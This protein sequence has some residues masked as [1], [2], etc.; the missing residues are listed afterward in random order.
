ME[1]ILL[2]TII[3]LAVLLFLKLLSLP[4]RWIFRLLI[5]TAAGFIFLFLLGYI[6]SSI[7][8]VIGINLFNA[9]IVGLLGLPGIAALLFA[10]W[11]FLL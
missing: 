7:G 1:K 11:I 10:R 4:I 5:N 9:A 3:T 8:L 6:G 2:I